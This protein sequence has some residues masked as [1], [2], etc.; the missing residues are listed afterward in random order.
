M[1]SRR[2]GLVV[3]YVFVAF[4]TRLCKKCKNSSWVRSNEPRWFFVLTGAW[5]KGR[6]RDDV[7]IVDFSRGSALFLYCLSER[8]SERLRGGEERAAEI[9]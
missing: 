1:K 8:E 7:T 6:A 5:I 9:F 2:Q 3:N 4:Q